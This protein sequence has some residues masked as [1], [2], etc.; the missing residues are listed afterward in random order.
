MTG[1]ESFH[2]LPKRWVLMVVLVCR[3]KHL[4]HHRYH[5]LR[6]YNSIQTTISVH[7]TQ[8]T[9]HILMS[10]IETGRAS[11][12]T[13]Q[14]LSESCSNTYLPR[15]THG[16]GRRCLLGVLLTLP[17]VPVHLRGIQHGV[18]TRTNACARVWAVSRL[19]GRQLFAL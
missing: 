8:N 19:T 11:S 7:T 3:A 12:S 15:G 9:R 4:P 17:C 13:N 2:C 6:R 16:R 1:H 14:A 10:R 18:F 5:I